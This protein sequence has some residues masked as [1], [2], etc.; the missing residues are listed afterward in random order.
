MNKGRYNLQLFDG[1]FCTLVGYI[2]INV[3]ETSGG[4]VIP[5]I[6][7]LKLDTTEIDILPPEVLKLLW[8]K[9]L[10]NM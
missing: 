10:R 1:Y 7:E 5:Y 8:R 4:E 2:I 3:L 9:Y 6:K